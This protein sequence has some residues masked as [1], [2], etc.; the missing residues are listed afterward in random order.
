M[1][2]IRRTIIISLL[3]TIGFNEGRRLSLALLLLLTTIDPVVNADSYSDILVKRLRTVLLVD[4]VL[5]L[6]LKAVVE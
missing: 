5:N 4:L 2:T 3:L 1:R 6:F